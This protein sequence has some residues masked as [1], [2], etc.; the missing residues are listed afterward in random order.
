MVSRTRRGALS[1][2]AA[3]VAR[4]HRWDRELPS[5]ALMLQPLPPA[6]RAASRWRRWR[7][8]GLC[9]SWLTLTLATACAPMP[10]RE[11]LDTR[12]AVDTAAVPSA[13]LVTVRDHRGTIGAADEV[14]TLDRVKAEG[15]GA[16][17]EHHLRVLAASGE[18]D[19]YRHNA[20]RL[21]V[22]GPATFAAMKA[23]VAQARQRVLLESYI[24]E[25]SRMADE[26]AALLRA[27]AREGVQIAVM[28]DA[29]GSLGTDSGYFDALARDGI[30][31]CKFNPINPLERPGYWGINHRNHRKVL[32]VDNEVAM[33]GGINISRVYTRRSGGSA[34]SGGSGGSGGSSGGARGG[35]AVAPDDPLADGWRDTHIELRG[36]VVPAMAAGF[37]RVWQSQGCKAVPANA[38]PPRQATPGQRVVK[39]LESDPREPS[40]RIYSTLLSAIDASQRSVHLSMA[41]FA[42]G[43]DMVRA[44]SDAAQRGVEVS[45]LLPGRSDFMLVLHAGRSYYERL[46]SA[47]VSIHEMDDAMMHAKTAVIDGV[48]STVGSSNMDWRSFVDNNE[49]NVIVLGDDFGSELERLFARDQKAS[50]RID[51]A[52]WRQR[53]LRQRVLEGVGRLAERF[54]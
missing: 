17:L 26:L 41:Y 1:D 46:L 28:Y 54:L 33:T 12:A 47:G 21:L 6:E 8:A 32:V 37:V 31:V 43:E 51:P 13:Q 34:G 24:I 15:G 7:G 52:A 40:N 27:K 48:L 29:V 45:L 14:R 36:P 39:V 19:L 5:N 3:F 49:I 25:D 4:A 18:V 38:A 42:P 9:A 23:A 2:N 20:T 22:D 53:D 16:L 11:R 50:R 35:D 10:A 30:A 44:L